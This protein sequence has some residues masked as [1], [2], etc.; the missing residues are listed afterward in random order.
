MEKIGYHCIIPRCAPTLTAA[1]STSPYQQLHRQEE[2]QT[3]G[4]SSD[5]ETD[6]EGGEA[7]IDIEGFACT[8]HYTP[9]QSSIPHPFQLRVLLAVVASDVCCPAVFFFVAEQ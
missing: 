8:E 6:D 9:G 3:I 7:G 4:E 1:A 2:T 5:E